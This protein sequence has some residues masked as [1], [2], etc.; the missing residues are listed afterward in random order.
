LRRKSRNK[1]IK[2]HCLIRQFTVEKM[3]RKKSSMEEERARRRKEERKRKEKRGG[4][5]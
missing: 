2:G 5:G 4:K 3:D 1:T